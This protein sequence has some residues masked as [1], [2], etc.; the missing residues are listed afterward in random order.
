MKRFGVRTLVVLLVCTVLSTGYAL[1]WDH[2]RERRE[3]ERRHEVR[4]EMR[5]RE[6]RWDRA[7]ERRE[8]ERRRERER[9]ERERWRREH[10]GRAEEHRPAGWDHGRKTG[11]GDHSMP[12]GQAK[13]ADFHYG[14]RR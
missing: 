4:R 6:A 11:W 5:I 14:N 10:H 1:G 8:A 13:K 3:H 12:P 9:W 2:G 7:R